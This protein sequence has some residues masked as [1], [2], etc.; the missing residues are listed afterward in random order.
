MKFS[1]R[2]LLLVTVMVALA[3]GWWVDRSWQARKSERLR[4]S[5][6]VEERRSRTL[7]SLLRSKGLIVD[8]ADN[9]YR[10]FAIYEITLP[11]SQAPAPNLPT[12]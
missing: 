1:I 11:N 12:P 8:F 10:E 9:D 6:S 7:L 3:L 4:Q 5:L 2:D